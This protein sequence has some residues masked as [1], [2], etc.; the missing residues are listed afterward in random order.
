MPFSER[1]LKPVLLTQSPSKVIIVE[2]NTMEEQLRLPKTN[3][4]TPKELNDA[5][6]QT[7]AHKNKAP[8]C[9]PSLPSPETPRVRQL[10]F[11]INELEAL[12]LSPGSKQTPEA[13]NAQAPPSQAE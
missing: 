9:T 11:F 1:G 8:P 2:L 12:A 7:S 13:T 3:R 6:T 4:T 10:R 5:Y